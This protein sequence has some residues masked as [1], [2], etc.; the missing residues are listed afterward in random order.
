MG[1]I[2]Y[3]KSGSMSFYYITYKTKTTTFLSKKDIVK[4]SAKT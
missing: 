2:L 1:L 3:P 4:V